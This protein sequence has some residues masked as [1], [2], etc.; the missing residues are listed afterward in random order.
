MT[1]GQKTMFTE[2]SALT[3]YAIDAVVVGASTCIITAVVHLTAPQN[4][5]DT[6]HARRIVLVAD[7][8]LQSR[9]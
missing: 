7:S 2:F 6:G 1:F 4:S 5:G 3:Q 9:A 8:V